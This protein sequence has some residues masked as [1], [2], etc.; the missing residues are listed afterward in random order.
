VFVRQQQNW[1]RQGARFA[2]GNLT[3]QA[4][5]RLV[6]VRRVMLSWVP[7]VRLQR[8]SLNPTC[9]LGFRRPSTSD[10]RPSGN[11]LKAAWMSASF[12]PG[13]GQALQY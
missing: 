5:T 12:S 2:A 6:A 10:A 13:A 8:Q 3:I 9:T 1:Q 7:D 4:P 11:F